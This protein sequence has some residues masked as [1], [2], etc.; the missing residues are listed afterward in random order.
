M[1]A[2]ERTSEVAGWLK[3]MEDFLVM[4]LGAR[5][6]L[7][8]SVGRLDRAD[9]EDYAKEEEGCLLAIEVFEGLKPAPGDQLKVVARKALEAAAIP[10]PAL[11]W[12]LA[13]VDGQGSKYWNHYHP[14]R[15][16]PEVEWN[17]PP[18]LSIDPAERAEWAKL[19]KAVV[20]WLEEMSDFLVMVGDWHRGVY[21]SSGGKVDAEVRTSFAEEEAGCRQAIKVLCALPDQPLEELRAT[22]IKALQEAEMTK[23]VLEW[24]GAVVIGEGSRFWNVHHPRHKLPELPPLF[25]ATEGSMTQAEWLRQG[26]S[27]EGAKLLCMRWGDGEILYLDKDLAAE[28]NAKKK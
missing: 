26:G 8:R 14:K 10:R 5:R 25:E 3:E 23:K 20:G 24:A 27:Y 2:P 15:N 13:V 11:N 9:A 21:D 28:M 6:G 18:A 16:A 12:A 4:T 7:E 1:N 22:A 19:P 17:P